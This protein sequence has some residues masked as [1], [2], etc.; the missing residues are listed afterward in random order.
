MSDRGEPTTQYIE[1]VQSAVLD[2]GDKDNSDAVEAATI[3]AYS[4]WRHDWPLNKDAFESDVIEFSEDDMTNLNEFTDRLQTF[5]EGD[6]NGGGGNGNGGGSSDEEKEFTIEMGGKTYKVKAKSREA[7]MAKVKAKY[8]AMKNG[9]GGSGGS[10]QMSEHIVL[11]EDGNEIP[12][13]STFSEDDRKALDSWKKSQVILKYTD[14]VEGLAGI[15]G[16]V[17]EKATKLADLEIKLGEDHAKER[18]AEWKQFNTAADQAGVTKTLLATYS[19]G[20]DTSTPAG[21]ATK[22]VN[23]YAA[24]K[25]ITTQ[26]ALAE[27]ASSDANLFKAFYSENDNS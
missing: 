7:A 21:E 25:K 2:D 14:E 24:E 10:S 12:D 13:P 17:K 5:A 4:C 11:D 22:R 20:T 3:L 23:E 6:S 18:L 8:A 26:Q 9:N 1:R 16:T 27:L 19:E 15:P